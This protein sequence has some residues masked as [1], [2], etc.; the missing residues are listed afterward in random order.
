MYVSVCSLF[1]LRNCNSMS[2]WFL[3]EFKFCN[4]FFY[5]PPTHT[6]LTTNHNATAARQPAA[7]V[8]HKSRGITTLA[9]M[10]SQQ[11]QQLHQQQQ[12]Q[13]QYH[14]QPL[15]QHPSQSQLQIQ[16]QEPLVPARLRQAKEK[17]NVESK[18]DERGLPSL[19]LI[20]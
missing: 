17:T 12:H 15:Q 13:Q 7:F 20:S 5:H 14:Q 1:A 19:Q 10:H 9:S 8:V 3:I 16:Q 6:R 2:Y 18:A 11:Q 4:F